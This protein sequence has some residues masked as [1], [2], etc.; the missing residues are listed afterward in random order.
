MQTENGLK[1]VYFLGIS[2]VGTYPLV[3]PRTANWAGHQGVL[4][5]SNVLVKAI[6]GSNA[7]SPLLATNLAA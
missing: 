2:R 6:K 7:L 4:Q 3:V 1:V 5:T